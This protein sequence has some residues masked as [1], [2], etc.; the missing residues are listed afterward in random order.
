MLEL[1]GLSY[2]KK[3]SLDKNAPQINLDY[4]IC[5]HSGFERN[6]L[7]KLHAALKIEEGDQLITSAKKAK[8]VDPDYSRF[9]NMNEFNWAMI[10]GNKCINNSRKK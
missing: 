1:S 9:K 2:Q 6:F 7:W 3:F 8:A 5:N 4:T 10:E